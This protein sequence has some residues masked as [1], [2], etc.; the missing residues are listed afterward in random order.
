MQERIVI[1]IGVGILVEF[2]INMF[3]DVGG[4]WENYC[5]EDVVILEVFQCDLYGV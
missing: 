4:L 1:F 3:C 5:I 2:G